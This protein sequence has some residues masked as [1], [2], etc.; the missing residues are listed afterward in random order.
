MNDKA[1]NNCCYEPGGALT[2]RQYIN[3]YRMLVQR[4]V[5]YGTL[6]EKSQKLRFIR[7]AAS[8]K[9]NF[10]LSLATIINNPAY[11]KMVKFYQATE[12]AMNEVLDATIEESNSVTKTAVIISWTYRTLT[13]STMPTAAATTAMLRVRGRVIRVTLLLHTSRCP[14]PE[15]LEQVRWR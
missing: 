15:H 14:I 11:D 12:N 2:P 7:Q 8:K 6:D 10:R 1:L 13:Y 4:A 3:Q 9:A 5:N